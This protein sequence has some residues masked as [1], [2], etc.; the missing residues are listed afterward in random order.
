MQEVKSKSLRNELTYMYFYNT[1]IS[2]VKLVPEILVIR[3]IDDVRQYV[4]NG[5]Q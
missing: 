1:Q 3:K 4:I 2:V 5:S